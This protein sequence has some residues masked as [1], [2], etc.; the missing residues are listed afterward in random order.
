MKRKKTNRLVK[1]IVRES[2]DE[3]I[4]MLQAELESIGKRT[5]DDS[6]FSDSSKSIASS[7]GL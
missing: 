7:R 2:K 3:R 4:S 6:M 5:D 1:K